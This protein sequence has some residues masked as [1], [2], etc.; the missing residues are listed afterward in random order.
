[1]GYQLT[2][3]TSIEN[4]DGSFMVFTKDGYAAALSNSAGIFLKTLLE[5][6]DKQNTISTLESSYNIKDGNIATE[7]D[8][9]IVQFIEHGILEEI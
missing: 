5:I 8:S 1:M 7:I 6:N 3:G 9:M 4:L 2:S